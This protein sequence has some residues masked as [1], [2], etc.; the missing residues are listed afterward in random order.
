[1]T[2]SIKA[3]RAEAGAV[4]Q[5]GAHD[6]QGGRDVQILRGRGDAE[7]ADQV[8]ASDVQADGSKIGGKGF[9]MLPQGVLGKFVDKAHKHFRNQLGLSRHLFQPSGTDDRKQHQKQHNPP[10]HHHRFRHRNAAE[11]RDG[12]GN[13]IIQLSQQLVTQ[14]VHP[15]TPFYI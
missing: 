6:G 7:H 5:G 3:V 13:L 4:D 1:M 12:K 14:R 9:P 11:Y 2:T 8:G 10:G 15:A